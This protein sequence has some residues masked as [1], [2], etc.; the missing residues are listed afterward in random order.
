MRTVRFGS[1]ADFSPKVEYLLGY[2]GD[3]GDFMAALARSSAT[4]RIGGDNVMPAELSTLLGATP[5][6][7]RAKG[8]LMK[9]GGQAVA[10]TGLW[11]LSAT[12]A[13]PADLDRQVTEILAQLPSDLELWRSLTSRYR[14]DLFC[15]WFMKEGDEGLEI[16]A[17]TLSAL[18][19]RGIK[20]GVCLY[21]P[22][23]S[24]VLQCPLSVIGGS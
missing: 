7:A 20:L 16:S 23:S 13:E 1:A 19:D 21:A 14:V 12:D 15:G 18:G 10:R 8:E 6:R 2:G 17:E 9:P 22:T 11:H 5:T 24:D 4:F 3:N